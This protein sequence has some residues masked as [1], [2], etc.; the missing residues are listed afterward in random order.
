M[1]SIA[2]SHHLLGCLTTELVL[3]PNSHDIDDDGDGVP[4]SIDLSPSMTAAGGTIE[5]G[6]PLVVD[7]MEQGRLS[8]VDLQFRPNNPDHLWYSRS[9]LD[10]PD[11]DRE[12]NV[13]RVTD[14][15]I[16]PGLAGDMRLVPLIEIEIPF[17]PGTHFGNLPVVPSG[18][19]GPTTVVT[20]WL[21]TE[22]TDAF[23]VTV[24]RA[25]DN[26]D[27]VA[28][29]PVTT[30]QDP[31][32]N[33]PVAFSARMPYRPNESFFG[34]NHTV[35]FLWA[36]E[37]VNDVCVPPANEDA[38]TYCEDDANWTAEGT[39]IAHIY[40]DDWHLTGIA[41]RTD[42]DWDAAIAYEPQPDED[43]WE[44]N[45]WRF[46]F[47]ADQ[48]F[49]GGYDGI[50]IDSLVDS[51]GDNT[52]DQT[53]T[54]DPPEALTIQAYEY[55]NHLALSDFLEEVTTVLSTTYGTTQ[56]AP[57]PTLLFLREE[58]FRAANLEQGEESVMFLGG[59]LRIDLNS[60]AASV[61]TLRSVS[62]TPYMFDGMRWEPD[63]IQ[64]Y[65]DRVEPQYRGLAA[66]LV[67]GE[68]NSIL[69]TDAAV[70][71]TVFLAQIFYIGYFFGTDAI[72][73]SDATL[74]PD[75]DNIPAFNDIALEV[76][77]SAAIAN[78]NRRAFS[79][80][81]GVFEQEFLSRINENPAALAALP[82][83]DPNESGVVRY[84]RD[85]HYLQASQRFHRRAGRGFAIFGGALAIV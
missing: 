30:V 42:L 14:T 11:N 60:A 37:I 3:E 78:A 7:G 63:D 39:Q 9:I 10:W 85:N 64:Q 34:P 68:G 38:F 12:G 75:P 83:F 36:V 53:N 59:M 28:Y 55:D 2:C 81:S 46:A 84:T 70:N 58:R 44:V 13:R 62:W 50:D 23:N 4:D 69:T 43:G 57:N 29:V 65:L 5:A 27:L 8:Y 61:D 49:L 77:G 74:L 15:P 6:L 40:E 67:D 41:A 25:N 17:T 76:Y 51:F 24:R 72:V 71:S 19:I 21:D 45:L 79:A 66:E 80:I 33:S 31:T 48:L 73:Q 20:T 35:N 47:L 54:L 1:H 56:P 52:P 18:A 32:G 82:D 16:E 26:G 22:V